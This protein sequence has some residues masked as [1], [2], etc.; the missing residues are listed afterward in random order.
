MLHFRRNTNIQHNPRGTGRSG[1][2]PPSPTHPTHP[3][4]MWIP[5]VMIIATIYAREWLHHV[6]IPPN[7]NNTVRLLREIGSE[8]S[9]I[10]ASGKEL[11]SCWF[12]QP[13]SS[14][15]IRIDPVMM[16]LFHKS[17]QPITMIEDT[18]KCGIRIHKT[19]CE[20]EGIWACQVYR[21]ANQTNQTA[22]THK[23]ATT[24]KGMPTERVNKFF[25]IKITKEQGRSA[26]TTRPYY[27]TISIVPIALLMAITAAIA[28]MT[29]QPQ[30]GTQ[31]YQNM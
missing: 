8:T 1:Q 27:Y 22:T 28:L 15:K 19:N 31:R 25:K 26:G 7:P 9:L 13:N 21:I 16:K 17:L 5:L 20:H 12:K 23:G 24:W 2:T 11:K 29:K 30:W 18:N 4:E 14:H 10:C 3:S 6:T